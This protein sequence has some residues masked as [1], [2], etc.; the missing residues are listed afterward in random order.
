MPPKQSTSTASASSRAAEPSAKAKGK[1][2]ARDDDD[3]AE[4]DDDEDEEGDPMEIEEDIDLAELRRP[5]AQREEDN[6][7]PQLEPEQV[8][9]EGLSEDEEDGPRLNI[10][11][12]LLTRILHEFFEKEGTRITG[13][14][15]EAVVRYM[16]VFVKEAIARAAAERGKGFLEVEDLEKIAPQLLLDV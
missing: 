16:D 14:A 8:I 10:P 13:D 4:D 1:Q 5:H 2:H 11:P 9:D 12:A 6:D 7:D 3:E 15:N